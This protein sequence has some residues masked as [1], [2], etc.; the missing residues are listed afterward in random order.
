[1]D[2]RGI[3]T[4]NSQRGRDRGTPE[5]PAPLRKTNIDV[6]EL[7]LLHKEGERYPVKQLLYINTVVRLTNNAKSDTGKSPLKL[8]LERSTTC[9]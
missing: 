9:N 8:F 5:D 6:P 4:L 7:K 3:N 1:M 2:E